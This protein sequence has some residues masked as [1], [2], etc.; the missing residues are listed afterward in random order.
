MNNNELFNSLYDKY[1]GLI[2]KERIY[3]MYRTYRTTYINVKEA[4]R[5][6]ECELDKEYKRRVLKEGTCRLIH[7]G[8][9]GS[10]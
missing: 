4:D 5:L 2:D 10:R 7:I 3:L 6:L 1:H 8:K 9:K